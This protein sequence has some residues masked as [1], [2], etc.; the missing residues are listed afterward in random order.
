MKKVDFVQFNIDVNEAYDKLVIVHFS[1][2]W[3]ASCKMVNE[4]LSKIEEEFS[5]K[6]VCFEINYYKYDTISNI[7]GIERVPSVVF[8]KDSVYLWKTVGNKFLAYEPL[9]DRAILYLGK[10]DEN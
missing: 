2:V 7:F 8:I 4:N 9:R 5:P 6:I 10:S 1:S 3:N